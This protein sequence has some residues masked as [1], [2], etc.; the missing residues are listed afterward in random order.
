MY[1]TRVLIVDDSHTMCALVQLE[2]SSD[3][4]LEVVAVAHNARDARDA[5]DQFKP[6]VLTLDIEMP[7]M[8]GLEF[9]SRVMKHR[10]TPVVMVSSLTARNKDLSVEALS[11]GAV[12]L[13]AK[14]GSG[15]GSRNVSFEGLAQVVREAA[16]AKVVSPHRREIASATPQITAASGG[17]DDKVIAIGSSTG[18]VDALLAVIGQFPADCPPT[19]VTQ[20]M[21]AGFTGSFANRLDAN[22]APEV[23]EAR[24]GE[25]LQRGRVYLAPGGK[26]HLEV[27]HAKKLICRL[28]EAPPVNGHR[29]SVDVLFNSVANMAG[30]N[31][32]GAILTGMGADG[33]QGLL[34]IRNAGGYTV[35]QDRETSVIYGMPRVAY[36]MGAVC[37]QLPLPDIASAILNACR[38]SSKRGVA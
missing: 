25:V 23:V 28:R 1:R 26:T 29:P 36:E 11:R 32:V 7:G 18:G 2:L 16:S 14:P 30:A 6:D 5:I 37:T 3:P 20:H 22:A 24:S 8:D 35:G 15:P 27:A 38:R 9:L 13:F 33:A 10:P 17:F 21:P 19:V 12:D 4:E 31:V 34:Q